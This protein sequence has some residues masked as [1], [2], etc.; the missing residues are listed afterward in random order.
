VG[1]RLPINLTQ[2]SPAD[3]YQPAFSADGE[4]IAFR[5]DRE[6]GGIFMMGRTGEAVRRIT[7]EGFNPSFSPD[8]LQ[9]AYATE[10]V[11]VMPLNWE[12]Q[13]ELYVADVGSG[14]ARR[15]HE[16]NAVSPA[17]SPDGRWI[18]FTLRTRDPTQMD[19]WLQPVDGTEPVQVTTLESND[20]SA[21]WSRDGRY[22][23]FVSDR[24]GTMNLW[25]VALD[26]EAG[27]VLGAP[28]PV[29]TP[30]AAVAH[31]T[32]SGDGSLVAY[33][34]VLHTMNIEKAALDWQAGTLGEI[35]PLTSG[36]R[37]WANPDPTGDG[38]LVV[39]YSQD[40]PEGDLYVVR[41]DGTGLRQVTGDSA[42]DRVPRISS[43]GE[44]IT[45]FSTRSGGFQV[46]VTRPDGSGNRQVT[47]GDGSASIGA[48]SPDGARLAVNGR[49]DMDTTD[50]FILKPEEEWSDDALVRLPMPGYPEKRF[51]VTD[52]SPDGRYL[53]GMQ[54]F[55]DLGGGVVVHDL[56]TGTYEVLTDF[57]QWP[58][59]L[60][61]SR[62][63]LFV[64]QGTEYHVVDRTTREIR[65]V[66]SAPRDVLGPPTLTDDGREVFYSRRHSEGDI[67]L[68]RFQ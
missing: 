24:S 5:S 58:V 12:G 20:W 1:G 14:E 21:A 66:Y 6:G 13:S 30:G 29:T 34:S 38:S 33:S 56:E 22:I 25:R 3:D 48:W 23:Y 50:V 36:S 46:W 19:I 54:G 17:W 45:Y 65:L 8:G 49:L 37:R 39:F 42:I 44:W 2:D 27:R 59:W 11:D 64:T 60:P 55:L 43:D 4:R 10:T 51:L 52:W 68:V 28:E 40:L 16:G 18:A 31:P 53:A 67:W 15:L 63:L 57:G 41:G 26:S 7:R 32:I 61:D 9:I 35:R 62:H 47:F